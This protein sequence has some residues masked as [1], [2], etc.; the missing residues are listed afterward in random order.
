MDVIIN[1]PNGL[2]AMCGTEGCGSPANFVWYGNWDGKPRYCC[3]AH[4]PM[5]LSAALPANFTG[6]TIC[7]ACGQPVRP[8]VGAD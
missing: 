7:R 3:P 2:P 5:L 8:T 4:N 6:S 1:G